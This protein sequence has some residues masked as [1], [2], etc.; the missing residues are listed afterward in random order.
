MFDRG[1]KER[2]TGG[3]ERGEEQ[4]PQER[5]Q[6]QFRRSALFERVHDVS[7]ALIIPRINSEW[8]VLSH[9][10]EE[11]EEEDVDDDDDDDVDD[12]G[13]DECAQAGALARSRK[14]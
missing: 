12:D 13:G 1:G 14:T 4:L 5:K 8:A 3:G 10:D 7:P 9:D 2:F 11:E 6:T